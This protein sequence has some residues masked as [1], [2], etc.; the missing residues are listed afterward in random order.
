MTRQAKRSYRWETFILGMEQP[1]TGKEKHGRI[2][3][4]IWS[5]MLLLLNFFFFSFLFLF[6]FFSFGVVCWEISLRLSGACLTLFNVA[7]KAA[8]VLQTTL[9]TAEKQYRT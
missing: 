7:T 3:G 5:S 9:C 1:R 2:T 8:E 6:F 4:T